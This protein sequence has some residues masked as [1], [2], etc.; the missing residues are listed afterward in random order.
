MRFVLIP[1]AFA[2]AAALLSISATVRAEGGGPAEASVPPGS[3]P[4]SS[5]E[6]LDA[7]REIQVTLAQMRTAAVRVRDDLRATRRRGTRAQIRCVDEALS[8]A[9]VA[10]RHARELADDITSAYD[11]DNLEQARGARRRLAELQEAQR[12]AAMLAAT[13][14]P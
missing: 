8:R 2:L 1:A 11:A 4:S 9:D 3:L 13:C 6:A 7:R 5:G 14:A 10:L 12:Q